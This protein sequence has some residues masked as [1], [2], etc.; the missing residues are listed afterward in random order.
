MKSSLELGT[1]HKVQLKLGYAREH[2]DE[3]YL[4][5]SS[6]DFEMTP[7]RRYAATE[8][9]VMEWDRT[10]AVLEWRFRPSE[11]L[12]IRTVAY[13][14]WLDRS[15]TKLNGFAGGVDLH[16]LLYTDPDSGQGA[17]YLAILR[18]E[19]DSAGAG[20]NLLLGTNARQFHSFGAQSTLRWEQ[21]GEQVSSSFEAGIRVHGD[22][23]RRVHTEDPH[24]MVAGRMQQAELPTETILD[25][26]A[27]VTALAAYVYEDLAVGKLHLFPSS[28]LEMVRGWREDQGS[29]AKP[30][31]TR[32]SILPGFGVLYAFDDWTDAFASVHRGF[33]P[34]SPGQPEEILPEYSWNYEAGLR[35][36]LG[37]FRG[38]LVG[39]FNDYSNLTGQ[40][41][42][43]S[44]C[45]EQDLDRQF[46]GG[47]VHIVGIEA[48][49]GLVIPVSKAM[50]LPINL[51]YTLTESRFLTDF[52]S[53]F[54]QFGRVE[55]GDFA[56]VARHRGRLQT[57]FETE[58][59]RLGL[60]LSYRG[61]MMDSAAAFGDETEIVVPE[62]MLL[63]V[64]GGVEVSD[65]WSLYLSGTN[66]L[67]TQQ[68]TAW[69]PWG[70]RPTAPRQ[71][72]GGL[73]WRG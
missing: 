8:L 30:T 16:D 49:S 29:A 63:D 41:T 73:K 34:V 28:R 37:V 22:D 24:V 26:H 27:G 47:R 6:G 59:A 4:G 64:G 40:C 58:R 45:D 2:S 21:F 50:T 71:I 14:H 15:W 48:V 18:G 1:S 20:Q 60:G 3:T 67:N 43:S 31:L 39:F 11:S 7:F 9:A 62:L 69:R 66:L 52:N 19:E 33:S 61:Q 65:N 13:H 35:R 53:D 25:S 36:N 5:L 57:G 46:N 42:F 54:A 12:K 72:M 10:Q 38:E 70:A 56:F 44:G 68:L 51:T 23:V 32:P 17:V 55:S